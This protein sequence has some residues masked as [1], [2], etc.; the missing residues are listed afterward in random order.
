MFDI[1]ILVFLL[2]GFLWGWS[3]G[4]FAQL[5]SLV[6]AIIGFLVACSLYGTLGDMLAPQI[7]TTPTLGHIIA[8]FLIWI[9][10]PVFCT[11]LGKFLSGLMEKIKLGWLNSLMGALFSLFK[12]LLFMSIVLTFLEFIDRYKSEP[13]V[14]Q[15]TKEESL[16]YYPVQTF[17]GK[18][19]P[20][21]FLERNT[22]DPDADYT[23]KV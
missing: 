16:L 17:A 7:G 4:F 8:F 21:N 1:V 9:L 18:L 10:V 6:G 22:S 13:I 15:D 3:K 11:Y 12:I 5:F 19:L 2:I 20:S 14:G 23:Q